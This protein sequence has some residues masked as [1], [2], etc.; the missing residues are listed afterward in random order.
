M[1]ISRRRI[2]YLA[3]TVGGAAII[4]SATGAWLYLGEI[5]GGIGRK[6]R[7]TTVKITTR[8]VETAP[9]PY[10]KNVYTEGEKSLVS[11]VLGTGRQKDIPKMV[12]SSVD[13]IGGIEKID[14]KGRRVLVKPN[15]NS[16]NPPPAVTNP[17]IVRAIVEMLFEA[18]AVEVT[19]GDCSNP[20]YRTMDVMRDQGLKEAT[21][22]AGGRVASFD[23]E[24][25]I[26]V[27]I[28][29]GRALT[30]TL[31]AKSVYEA[32]R[33]V[34]LPVLKTHNAAMFSMSMKNFV[35]AI[36]PTSRVDPSWTPSTKVLHSCPDL[37]EGIAELNLLVKPDLIVMDGTKSFV[38]WGPDE[39][40]VRDTNL[41]VASGDRIANDIVGLS[42]I[43][44]YGLWPGVVEKDVWDQ[45]Q[46]KR[47]LELGLGRGRDQVK[48]VGKSL[49]GQDELDALLQKIHNISRIPR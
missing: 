1:P 49:A 44:T 9:K 20:N 26:R 6:T 28:P 2:I 43:K 4:V 5:S 45:G 37:Q 8:H 32:E 30:E 13:F 11:I 36:K 7:T 40:E 31:I 15:T 33:L 38:Y 29:S 23:E 12:K 16:N 27:E 47:G 18:G 22:E 25:W 41:V 14:V 24:E 39:G 19:V 10:L 35:G 48:I 3:A 17:L 46:I 34:D 42:V 21:E